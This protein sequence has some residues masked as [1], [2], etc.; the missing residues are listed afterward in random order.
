MKI[1][2]VK[3]EERFDNTEFSNEVVDGKA[4][5][6][7]S[8][9]TCPYCATRIRFQKHDFESSARQR[10][11]NLHPAVAASF[12]EFARQHL[13]SLDDFLDWVCSSCGLAARVYARFW[14]GGK[15]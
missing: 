3:A 15:H 4:L 7:Y 1:T 10:H 2:S 11:S 9:Y 5:S 14:A 13:S 12:D 8:C 6:I